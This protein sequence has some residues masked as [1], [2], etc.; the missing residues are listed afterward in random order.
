MS[1]RKTKFAPGEHFHIFNRGNNKQDTFL[2]E[3]DYARFLF[4]ILHLQSEQSFN[5]I[6]YSVT[7]FIKHRVFDKIKEMDKFIKDKKVNLVGF[8]LM[9][10]HFHLIVEQVKDDGIS[11]YMQRVQN[12]YT[13]YFN[14]KYRKTGHLL[15]GPFKAVH[16]DDN[17][18]LLHLSAYTHR[19]PRELEHWKGKEHQYEWSSYQDYLGT[20]RWGQLLAPDI[21]KDQFRDNA[22]YR[23]FVNKSS[24][25]E[26]LDEKYRI[27]NEV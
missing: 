18:Q 3:R 15:Q 17:R 27:D 21:I 23:N 26:S 25:K 10:N 7:N 22:E 16:I 9:S 24:A 8:I 14:T 12:A 19:N 11:D 2:S 4:L 6:G 13:K 5:N 20:N 1:M